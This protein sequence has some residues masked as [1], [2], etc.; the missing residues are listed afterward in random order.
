VT[1]PSIFMVPIT[2]LTKILQNRELLI[3]SW[4]IN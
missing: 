1:L 4:D 3:H 2:F